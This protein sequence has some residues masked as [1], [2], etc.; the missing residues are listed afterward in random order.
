VEEVET[1]EDGVGWGKFL[2]AKILG[3]FNKTVDERKKVESAEGSDV[4]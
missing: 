1:D 2:R 4:G 3:G